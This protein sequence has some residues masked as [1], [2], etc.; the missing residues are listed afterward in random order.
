MGQR[1]NQDSLKKLLAISHSDTDQVSIRAELGRNWAF[2]NPDSGLWYSQSA[3]DMARTIHFV[4][5]EAK[6]LNNYGWNLSIKGNFPLGIEYAFKALRLF[7]SIP[8]PYEVG[9]TYCLLNFNFRELGDYN[10][11]VAYGHKALE[12]LDPLP[13]TKSSSLGSYKKI[14]LAVLGETYVRM[15]RTDSALL[16]VQKAY[17][18]DS[19]ENEGRWNYPTFVMANIYFQNHSYDTARFYYLQALFLARAN[20]LGKDI[21]DIY[22]SLARLYLEK[23]MPDSAMTC[24]QS[25]WQQAITLSY[26]KGEMEAL[27]SLATVFIR[28]KQSDSAIQYLNL[29][30]QYRDSLFNQEKERHI[31]ALIFNEQIKKREL[32]DIIENA[33]RQ[34]RNMIEA[35]VA[36]FL[37]VGLMASLRIYYLKQQVKMQNIR[38]EISHD[39]H[40]DLGSALGSINVL[41]QTLQEKMAA[42]EAVVQG[43]LSML[44]RISHSTQRS[45]DAIDDMVWSVN[46]HKDSLKDL[47]LRMKEFAYPLAE[48]CSIH[49]QLTEE[50]ESDKSLS[51]IVR[52][53]VFLIFKEGFIN[54]LKYAG[55]RN[56]TTIISLK[57]NQL[58]LLIKD[59]GKGFDT[60]KPTSR[61]GLTNMQ[62]RAQNL[63]GQLQIHS[64]PGCGT[65]VEL[66]CP[67]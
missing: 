5:G 22:N 49:F 57:N 65:R 45:L 62:T 30:D 7:E 67:I 2:L 40:D 29:R 15:G 3:I 8:D 58:V 17:R 60:K 28:E 54:A 59:D 11:A 14:A 53:N 48:A 47:I 37:I 16:Y 10:R 66:T 46:P 32:S 61:S 52:K 31:Q 26:T 13:I 44:Q 18:I 33:R 51:M 27:S 6:G 1:I 43:E 4:K 39:L 41:S 19:T 64:C 38:I 42:S 36:L 55:S 21:S 12:T 56:I 50:G 63:Q 23:Q 24:A 25:A 20:N 9:Y 34:K 35:I